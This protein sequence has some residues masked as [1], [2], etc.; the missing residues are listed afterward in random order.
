MGHVGSEHQDL[1]QFLY[2]AP[3]GLV[4]AGLDGHIELINAAAARWLLPLSGE[5]RLDNLFQLLAGVAPDLRQRVEHRAAATGVVVEGLRLELRGSRRGRDHPEHVALTLS[6]PG[7]ARLMA[8]FN[9]V[10]QQVQDA[11]ALSDR[12]AHYHAVVSVLSEG[13]VVHDAQGALLMCNA[14]AER[15]VG[16]PWSAAGA[17]TEHTAGWAPLWPDGQPMRQE[18]T[19]TGIVLAGG[20]AQERVPMF[21]I[22]DSGERRWFDVSAQPVISPGSG[23]LLAVVTSFTDVTQRQLLLEQLHHHREHL[24]EMVAQRTRELELSNQ[25]L[26]G[27][28]TLMRAVADAVPGMIGYW[29]ADLR[30]RFSNKAWNGSAARP[31]RCWTCACR[32]CWARSCSR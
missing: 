21:S 12:A 11:Q 16:M 24:Q 5:A 25:A 20:P 7:D 27:Q 32:S 10:T 15:I 30:C 23:Q 1:L 22:A 19:P 4:H 26:A 13:I 9:D 8:V 14:A 28:Q 17:N 2:A 18:D 31:K 3:V 29:D 6:V